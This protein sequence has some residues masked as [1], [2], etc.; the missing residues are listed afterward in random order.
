M[1]VAVD[2]SVRVYDRRNQDQFRLLR[3]TCLV[4]LK[5]SV[6]LIFAKVSV[7]RISIPLDLSSRSF[8]TLPCFIRSRRPIPLL[9]PSLVLFPPCCS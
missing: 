9:A 6:G 3:A 2:T 4:N 1:P 7:M 8:L 5:G